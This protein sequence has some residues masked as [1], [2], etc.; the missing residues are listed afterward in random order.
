MSGF[1]QGVAVTYLIIGAMLAC[2]VTR[3]SWDAMVAKTGRRRPVMMF[4][5]LFG[6]AV[7]WIVP[8][9]ILAWRRR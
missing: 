7:T 6:Y 2:A 5:A 8:A 9:L 1:W 4:L 3:T